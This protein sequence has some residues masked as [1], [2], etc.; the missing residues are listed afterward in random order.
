MKIL[1]YLLYVLLALVVIGI[2]LGI[3]GPKSYHVERSVMI[4]GTPDQVWPHVSSLKKVN[5]WSPFLKMDTAAVVEYTGNDGAVGSS[6]SWKSK[7]MGNGQQTISALDPKKSSSVHLK[8]DNP[9][10]ESEADGYLNLEPVKDSTKVTWSM[11]GDNNFVG[12]IM[13]SVMSIDKNVGPMF[14]SGLNDLKTMVEAEPKTPFMD[15][16]YPITTD[17]YPGGLYLAVR[18]LLPMSEISD[19]FAKSIPQIMNEIKKAKGEVSSPPTG[20]YYTWDEEKMETAMAAGVGIQKEFKTPAGMQMVHVPDLKSLTLE[21]RGGYGKMGDAHMAI[22]SYIKN[23]NLESIPPVME[24]YLK[25]PGT[26][27]DSNKWVT[28]IV[29]LIK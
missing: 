12:K 26:E 1:K 4:S 10:G 15:P 21:Y 29:Y 16:N 3:V 14:E 5:E 7:K 28:K 18:K 11:K 2:I 13:M 9:W 19:F 24:E 22:S 25:G 20:L 17:Q 27:P 6:S 23:N 8:F